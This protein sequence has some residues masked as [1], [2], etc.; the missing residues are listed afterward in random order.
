MKYNTKIAQRDKT[1]LW[2]L[3]IWSSK[4]KG[5]GHKYLIKCGCCDSKIEIY[6]ALDKND[7]IEIGGVMASKAEW[8]KILLPLLG[9]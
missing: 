2:K 3:R 4:T 5:I 6:P 1:G 8:R 9:D 7:G